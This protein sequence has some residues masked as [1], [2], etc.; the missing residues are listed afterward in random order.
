MGTFLY[1][2]S[3][4]LH[5]PGAGQPESGQTILLRGAVVFAH[6][7]NQMLQRIGDNYF[8]I[9]KRSLRTGLRHV[10]QR[11]CLLV[12]LEDGHPGLGV[13]IRVC[14]HKE[15]RDVTQ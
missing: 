15:W 8:P 7:K 11:P 9:H 5:N 1:W 6:G 13:G 3:D 4:P 10:C 14:S 12:D 2:Y